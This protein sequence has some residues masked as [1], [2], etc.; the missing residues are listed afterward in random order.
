MSRIFPSSKNIETLISQHS[1]IYFAKI[2]AKNLLKSFQRLKNENLE[3]KITLMVCQNKIAKDKGY[4]D[5]YTL[6]NC[7]KKEIENSLSL[8][9]LDN[10][11]LKS[12]NKGVSNLLFKFIDDKC[13][14]SF[15]N[16]E[17]VD[18]K[19]HSYN[20]TDSYELLKL[21][22]SLNM[23]L[24]D[25][26]HYIPDNNDINI[27]E[28]NLPFFSKINSLYFINNNS[29]YI[30]SQ[31]NAQSPNGFEVLLSIGQGVELSSLVDLGYTLQQA[32]TYTKVMYVPVGLNV[33]AGLCGQGKTKTI[34][35]MIDTINEKDTLNVVN[36]SLMNEK[37][38]HARNIHFDRIPQ[39]DKDYSSEAKMFLTCRKFR[40]HP[41]IVIWG[42]L[43]N[44]EEASQIKKMVQ[45]GFQM[46]TSLH[47]SSAIGIILRLLDFKI[48]HSVLS[49]PAFINSLSYQKLIPV[50]CPHC[51]TQA[52]K[53]INQNIQHD[54]TILKQRYQNVNLNNIKVH[55]PLG[56]TKCNQLGSIKREV[57]AEIIDIKNW[58]KIHPQVVNYI[59]NE[60]LSSLYTA[61]KSMSDNDIMSDNMDG[62]TC[63]EHC[64]KKVLEGKVSL[65]HFHNTFG[66][67]DYFNQ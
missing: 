26:I 52:I 51:S 14:I 34:S 56:C 12:I 25:N 1:L 46:I 9:I 19:T 11:L 5:W 16:K 48:S 41:D 63:W 60:D 18:K 36:A 32:Q 45:A 47:A 4:L 24:L 23:K 58:I 3:N 20:E 13:I 33:F 53:S 22:S 66:H 61:W 37:I 28:R 15:M 29:Y 17:K 8:N 43:R 7:V 2:E 65:S 31:Y 27:V 30:T 42:E 54:L 38:T 6:Y 39:Q 44:L 10:I 57:C 62:K 59:L 55:N 67:L 21:L 64:L 35:T 49:S 50:V 40:P